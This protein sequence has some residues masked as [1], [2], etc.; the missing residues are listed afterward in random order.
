MKSVGLR[1][2]CTS[3]AIKSAAKQI[4]QCGRL[5]DSLS[6]LREKGFLTLMRYMVQTVIKRKMS[7]MKKRYM[8]FQPVNR[9]MQRV[10]NTTKNIYCVRYESPELLFSGTDHVFVG[11]DF[12]HQHDYSQ[13]MYEIPNQLED[14]H[15]M[16]GYFTV[17]I[18]KII[19]QLAIYF[20]SQSLIIPAFLY[21]KVFYLNH[22][23]QTFFDILKL[24][25]FNI[26]NCF[27]CFTCFR[28]PC[29][30]SFSNRLFS[31]LVL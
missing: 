19:I 10:R 4:Q 9:S 26:T 14:V 8:V 18:C 28:I 6:Q 27:I 29:L 25:S 17:I 30:I 15:F 21:S 7:F 16:R 31:T 3:M 22:F 5:S 11:K 2:L 23:T 13:K 1:D 24:F 20:I 12:Q